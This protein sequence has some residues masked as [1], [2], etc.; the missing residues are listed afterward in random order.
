[1]P[2]MKDSGVSPKIYLYSKEYPDEEAVALFAAASQRFQKPMPELLNDFGAFLTPTLIEMYQ[3]LIR[4]Q[5]KT[6]DVLE[7][8]EESIH[9]VVRA[10]NAGAKPP[11]LTCTRRSHQEVVID[12]RSHR[13]V[14]DLMK[15][16]IRGL[17]TH[18]EEEIQV[19]EKTCML[20]GDPACQ[21]IARKV[22]GRDPAR[23]PTR[24]STTDPDPSS[25]R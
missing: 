1:M 22:Q 15:G 7:H 10:K 16:I 20:K 8:T 6:L 18:F 21:I 24:R 12:Y 19:T 13:R 4:P 2:L 11:N 9:K 23:P 17:S 25:P 5:W 3:N 14:C